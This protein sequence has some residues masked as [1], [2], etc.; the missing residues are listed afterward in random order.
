M[1]GKPAYLPALRNTGRLDCSDDDDDDDVGKDDEDEEELTPSLGGGGGGSCVPLGGMDPPASGGQLAPVRW[2]KKPLAARPP[3]H[4]APVAGPLTGRV[5]SR[6]LGGGGVLAVG[7]GRGNGGSG[8]S[9]PGACVAGTGEGG[10]GVPAV[11][12]APQAR[13]GAHASP[14]VLVRAEA[15]SHYQPLWGWQ[16]FRGWT[17]PAQPRQQGPAPLPPH[18]RGQVSQPHA[19]P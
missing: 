3:R 10:G 2:S 1:A 6:P 15:T 18:L 19:P 5:G 14:S 12:L 4:P 17:R 9:V 11:S 8:V 13:L 16:G 7:D